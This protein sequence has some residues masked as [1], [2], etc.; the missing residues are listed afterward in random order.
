M[1]TIQ[2]IKLKSVSIDK[3]SEGNVKVTGSYELLS[4]TDKIL[5]KQEFGGYQG[6][7]LEQSPETAKNLHQVM[8]DIKTDLE[9]QLGLTENE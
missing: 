9:K 6:I 5:A 7:K 1:I 3:D 2:G 4:N 8:L